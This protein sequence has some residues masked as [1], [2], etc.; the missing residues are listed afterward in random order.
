MRKLIVCLLLV[1]LLVPMFAKGEDPTAHEPFYFAFVQ[2]LE[3]NGV[4]LNDGFDLRMFSGSKISY[5]PVDGLAFIADYANGDVPTFEIKLY[6]GTYAETH[7]EQILSLFIWF[8]GDGAH[9]QS[10]KDVESAQNTLL[11]LFASTEKNDEGDLEA[12]MQYGKADFTLLD[13][14]GDFILRAQFSE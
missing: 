14:F 10:A 3:D 8:F 1:V 13:S 6:G 7:G 4:E 2:L 5:N 12:R 9:K 11:E